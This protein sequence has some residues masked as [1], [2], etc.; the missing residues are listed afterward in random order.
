MSVDLG[1]APTCTIQFGLGCPVP[2]ADTDAIRQALAIR[3]D[4]CTNGGASPLHRAEQ[5]R[6]PRDPN[7]LRHLRVK[8]AKMARIETLCTCATSA[9]SAF[10]QLNRDVE[11]SPRH[12]GSAAW[13]SRPGA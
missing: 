12:Q 2:T 5:S 8:E 4:I 13:S 6:L 11:L 7:A 1:H 9:S 10:T 3:A